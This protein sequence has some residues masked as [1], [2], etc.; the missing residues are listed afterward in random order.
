M[1]KWKER[2]KCIYQSE[3]NVSCI[4]RLEVLIVKRKTQRLTARSEIK[5]HEKI[6]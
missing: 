2:S 3:G 5:L 6:K 4:K 1:K